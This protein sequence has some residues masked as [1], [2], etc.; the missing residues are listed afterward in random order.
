MA[1]VAAFFVG[2]IFAL[3]LGLGGMT[4]PRR[5]V[6]FLDLFGD[7]DPSLIFVMFGALAI[8]IVMYRWIVRRKAPILGDRFHI[9]TKKTIDGPLILGAVLF[10]IGWGLAG[11]CPAPAITSLATFSL[12]PVVF[13]AS[14]LAG[15][16]L[17][18]WRRNAGTTGS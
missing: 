10:G 1:G 8:H 11:Y 18:H 5:V 2:L 13:V 9:P 4:Q 3:G 16:A 6:G 12:A 7:W 17:S 15:M 14:L